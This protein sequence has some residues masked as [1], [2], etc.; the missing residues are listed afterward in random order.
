MEGSEQEAAKIRQILNLGIKIHMDDF[1]TGYSSLATLHRYPIDALK[2]AREFIIDVDTNEDRS[3]VVRTIISF[4]R[5]MNMHVIA[6]GVE[7]KQQLEYLK[8]ENCD[9]WQGYLC[10]KALNL[11]SL[12]K[13]LSERMGGRNPG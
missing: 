10:S 2:I 8:K 7:N 3:E 9:I 5:I 12:E 13:Y 4:A 1:G 11:V 6:E